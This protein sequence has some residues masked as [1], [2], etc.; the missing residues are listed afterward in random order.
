MEEKYLPIGTV[1]LLKGGTKK[2]MINGYCAVTE[3]QKGKIFDYR[4][5][6]FPEGVLESSGVALFDHNQ[7]KEIVHMGYKNDESI[8][9]SDK[10]EIIVNSKAKDTK[11]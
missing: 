1:V 10:L 9:L 4:G 11:N 8:D 3:A 7:I 5:C 6:P 2:V